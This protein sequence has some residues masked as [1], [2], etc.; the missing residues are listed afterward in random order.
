[1]YVLCSDQT[2]KQEPLSSTQKDVALYSEELDA[3]SSISHLVQKQSSSD[4]FKRMQYKSSD[5]LKLDQKLWNWRMNIREKVDA[6]PTK[7][8]T[9]QYQTNLEQLIEELFKVVIDAS[10]VQM[11]SKAAKKPSNHDAKH[12]LNQMLAKNNHILRALNWVIVR[13][14]RDSFWTAFDGQSVPLAVKNEA[15]GYGL[16]VSRLEE[17]FSKLDS[18]N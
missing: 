13:Q 6:L 15:N 16:A 5:S 3:Q 8:L 7:G 9:N 12:V 14:T 1:M 18:P 10:A 17:N 11:I 2:K 4:L